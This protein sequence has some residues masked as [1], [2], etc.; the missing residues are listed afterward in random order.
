[1]R[2]RIRWTR[3]LARTR[4]TSRRAR[5]MSTR[6]GRTPSMTRGS[7]MVNIRKITTRRTLMRIRR[8]LSF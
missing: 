7:T 4:E 6:T 8:K 3:M 1:M 2:T 5:R